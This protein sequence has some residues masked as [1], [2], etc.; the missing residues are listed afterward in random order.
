MDTTSAGPK[1]YA[2]RELLNTCRTFRVEAKDI[3]SAKIESII[4]RYDQKR[5]QLEQEMKDAYQEVKYGEKDWKDFHRA[6][7]ACAQAGFRQSQA[8]KMLRKELA[9]VADLGQTD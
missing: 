2:R 5:V 4:A 8:R 9:W 3:Y 1:T 6:D 7:R